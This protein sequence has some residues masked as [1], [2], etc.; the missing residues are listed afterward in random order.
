MTK[1]AV[2]N[3]NFTVTVTRNVRPNFIKVGSVITPISSLAQTKSL[4]IVINQIQYS[5][6][7]S[8]GSRAKSLKLISMGQTFRGVTI[9]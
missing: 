9:N 5:Q 1:I 3:M 7:F 6:N 8:E 2:C 4:L